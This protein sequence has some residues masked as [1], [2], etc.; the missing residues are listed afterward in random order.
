MPIYYT[1][2]EHTAHCFCGLSVWTSRDM[3]ARTRGGRAL[4]AYPV[5]Q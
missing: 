4:C 2:S 1:Y 3:G 5:A